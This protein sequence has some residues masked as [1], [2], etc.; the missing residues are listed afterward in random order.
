MC[1]DSQSWQM[2]TVFL[3][4]YSAPPPPRQLQACLEQ[5]RL[6]HL[7]PVLPDSRTPWAVRS[8]LPYTPSQG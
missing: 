5:D 1:E 2:L 3:R 4:F 7:G 8:P 6:N